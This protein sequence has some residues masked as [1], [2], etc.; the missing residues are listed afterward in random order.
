GKAP[1]ARTPRR[2]R[3]AFR[4]PSCRLHVEALEDRLAPATLTWS[5]DA[6]PAWSEPRNWVGGITPYMTAESDDLIFPRGSVRNHT[7]NQDQPGSIRIHSIRFDDPDYIIQGGG[8][9]LGQITNAA[10]GGTN[11]IETRTLTIGRL[12]SEPTFIECRSNT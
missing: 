1:S 4:R 5:G 3:P 12:G 2:R 7:S 6:G 10:P 9:E 8:I 11:R